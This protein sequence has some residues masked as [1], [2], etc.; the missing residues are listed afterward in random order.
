MLNT[1]SSS[2][3]FAV[4]SP[5]S[6]G[7]IATDAIATGSVQWSG[8]PAQSQR[9]A[10]SVETQRAPDDDISSG[11]A[12]AEPRDADP[13]AV[14]RYRNAGGQVERTNVRCRDHRT[15]VQ[16]VLRILEKSSLTAEGRE[17]NLPTAIG[18]RVVHGGVEFTSSVRI[19]ERVKNSLTQLIDLAPLHN[20]PAL[21]AI[22]A[23]EEHLPGTPQYAVFDTA[24]FWQLPLHEQVYPLPYAW[25]SDWGIRRFGFHGISHGY[26]SGRAAELLQRT[27]A[28]LRLVIC[29]LGNGCSASALRG[30]TALATTMGL[31]PL[32]G[33]MM[34]SRSGSIDPG[35]LIH[36]QRAFNLTVDQ[37]DAA[38]QKDSGLLGVSGI[39][40]DF[41]QVEKA[42]REGHQRSAL[43]LDMY[44]SRIRS[45]VGSLAVQL[46]GLDALVFT[47]GVGENSAWL[48]GKVCE[49]LQCLGVQLDTDRNTDAQADTDVALPD[50]PVRVLVLR[51]N[52]EAFIAREVQ[53]LANS[54]GH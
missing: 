39:S 2:L 18:H 17:L 24:F 51:T 43:A 5:G 3:K 26:C 31:T 25:F 41:R 15:A 1:G 19:D 50:S 52:E 30:G 20:P 13:E 33:L 44:A 8:R 34:G 35:I 49:G 16:T 42:A 38:L 11:S 4:F 45:A 37:L 7:A 29:H 9:S 14:L 46:G 27:D 28:G 22:E 54:G 32:E 53:R 40:S 6:D 36:V 47:A 48:R 12:A 21:A 23:V 10:H